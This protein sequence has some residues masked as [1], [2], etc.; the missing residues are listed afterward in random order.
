MAIKRFRHKG[1]QRLYE[2]DNPKGVQAAHV[3]KI[4]RILHALEN[5][6]DVSQIATFPGWKLHPLKG[7]RPGEYAVWV[8]GSWR[9]IF[10][11]ESNGFTDLDLTDYH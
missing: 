3:S 2:D 6:T 1:L 7:D 8:T 5:A 4:K 10:R 9:I 11:P